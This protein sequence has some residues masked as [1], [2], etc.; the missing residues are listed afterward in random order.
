M[1]RTRLC[2]VVAWCLME[3]QLQWGRETA[4]HAP[5]PLGV[6]CMK[7]AAFLSHP[8][9]PQPTSNQGRIDRRQGRPVV[10]R[11]PNRSGAGLVM[12]QAGYNEGGK[13]A[14]LASSW[15]VGYN[16]PLAQAGCDP[17]LVELQAHLEAQGCPSSLAS[18]LLLLSAPSASV[19]TC[20]AALDSLAIYGFLPSQCARMVVACPGV[21]EVEG[22]VLLEWLN[23]LEGM[24]EVRPSKLRSVLLTNKEI[25]SYANCPPQ[26]MKRTIHILKKSGVPLNQTHRL[27]IR[28]PKLLT[29]PSQLVY[30]NLQVLVG[31]ICKMGPEQ[32]MSVL[33]KCPELLQY[34]HELSLRTLITLESAGVVGIDRV[35]LAQPQVLGSKR[36]ESV[37]Q[38]L[39]TVILPVEDVPKVVRNHPSL[40]TMQPSSML[41]MVNY[42]Q[43]LGLDRSAIG[44]VMRAYPHLLTESTEKADRVIQFLAKNQINNFPQ[45]IQQLPPILS[46]DPDSILRPKLHF[47]ERVMGLASSEVESFPG[48][49]SYPLHSVIAV[50]AIFL[51]SL[52]LPL[53]LVGLR[54]LVTNGD[55]DFC[56]KVAHI[57]VEEFR[58][59]KS[60]YL[61]SIQQRRGSN[62]PLDVGSRRAKRRSKRKVQ[63]AD[64]LALDSTN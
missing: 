34:D 57:S 39:A 5:I 31:P 61:A 32:V 23:S 38:Y 20:K 15:P 62:Y 55:S 8:P 46:Y 51:Q 53:S 63:L 56:M 54:R 12:T 64:K 59:F 60:A 18:Q 43:E 44:R 50:R 6:S 37:M 42:L 48:Y 14:A 9:A 11:R 13:R 17:T 1:M 40:L 58:R 52:G 49:F 7:P 27:L 36:A 10:G 16:W 29:L 3:S 24:L 26:Q 25:L 22:H 33:R 21:M 4:S 45:V 35:V 28:F 30:R 19:D 2:F 47:L 41:Q